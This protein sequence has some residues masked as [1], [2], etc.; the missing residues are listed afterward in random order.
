MIILAEEIATS[1]QDPR[2]GYN[3]TP[4]YSEATE[5]GK[6]RS[7]SCHFFNRILRDGES[8]C[9]C[10]YCYT[11][12]VTV[13]DI[14]I[15]DKNLKISNKFRDCLVFSIIKDYLDHLHS[16]RSSPHILSIMSHSKQAVVIGAGMNCVHCPLSDAISDTCYNTGV[17]GLTTALR[18][19]EKCE[20]AV[21]I[22][23]EVL[24]TDPKSIKYTSHW[25]VSAERL[26]PLHE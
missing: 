6:P 16:Q 10:T 2:R 1:K 11:G 7:S 9:E 12:K 4:T 25:A 22:I 23:A 20:Y 18:I 14:D 17:I 5:T 24:P 26:G 3:S 13:L 15:T 19:Q 8:T 21:S